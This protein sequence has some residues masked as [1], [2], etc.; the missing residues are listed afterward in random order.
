MKLPF[1]SAQGNDPT[2][3]TD[4]ASSLESSGA[5]V[6]WTKPGEEIVVCG[7]DRDFPVLWVTLDGIVDCVAFEGDVDTPSFRLTSAPEQRES[8]SR[9]LIELLSR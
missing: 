3:L 8:E 4:L 7:R 5:D 1:R 9:S 6:R 2:W